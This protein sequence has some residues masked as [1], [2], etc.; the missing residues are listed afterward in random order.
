LQSERNKM[1]DALI[2]P[3]AIIIIAFVALMSI[4]FE[5]SKAIYDKTEKAGK[6]DSTQVDSTKHN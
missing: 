2:V 3:V 4:I 6:A 5:P 1:K